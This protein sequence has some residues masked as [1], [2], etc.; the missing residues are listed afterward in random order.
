MKPLIP[1]GKNSLTE[2]DIKVVHRVKEKYNYLLSLLPTLSAIE[3]YVTDNGLGSKESF[4]ARIDKICWEDHDQL[5]LRRFLEKESENLFSVTFNAWITVLN[6]NCSEC[7][8]V[9]KRYSSFVDKNRQKLTTLADAP[10]SEIHNAAVE[11]LKAQ[12]KRH[13]SVRPHSLDFIETDW[14]NYFNPL[15]IINNEIMSLKS[16]MN[17]V[18]ANGEK[19]ERDRANAFSNKVRLGL[20]IA[21]FVGLG[22][23][24]GATGTITAAIHATPA[25]IHFV[26]AHWPF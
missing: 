1:N 26:V 8:N 4:S 6:S 18:I 5:S 7:E 17:A 12:Y 11:N 2:E 20:A 22:T 15:S 25:L 14:G 16:T 19:E 9:Y 13:A 23:V 24:A 3:A 21:S 10:K